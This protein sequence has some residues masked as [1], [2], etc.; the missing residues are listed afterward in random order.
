M[1]E[2]KYPIMATKPNKDKSLLD[3]LSETPYP[4]FITSAALLASY[5]WGSTR[6]RILIKGMPTKFSMISFAFIYAGSGYACIKGDVFNS[7]GIATAWSISYGLLNFGKA[8]S[9]PRH[10]LPLGLACTVAAQGIIYGQRYFRDYLGL[11]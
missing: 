1:S 2:E 8:F 7:T 11:E 3:L 9:S 4:A 5:R 6:D 10:P